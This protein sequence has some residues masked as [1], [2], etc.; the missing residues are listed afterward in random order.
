MSFDDANQVEQF[1]KHDAQ[2]ETSEN[3]GSKLYSLEGLKQ[4]R[5][6]MS[7][8]TAL[9]TL[10]PVDKFLQGGNLLPDL[11]IDGVTPEMAVC[12]SGRPV[13]GDAQKGGKAD[14]QDKS[15]ANP[16][17]KP[18]E[19]KDATTDN[20]ALNANNDKH[21]E[22]VGEMKKA[23][24]DMTPEEETKVR[25][26]LEKIDQ[27]PA[28]QQKKVYE[29][30]EKILTAPTDNTTKLSGEQRYEIAGSMAHQIAHPED[31]KQGEKQT[32]VAANAEK[33]MAMT[34]PDRYA[35]MVSGLA[36]DGKYTVTLPN[37][38]QKTIEA[39]KDA[40]GK[41]ADKTDPN[42]ER[43]YA[44]EVFQNFAMNIPMKDGESYKSYAPGTRESRNEKDKNPDGVKS[45]KDTGERLEK[46][47]PWFWEDKMNKFG[48]LEPGD[49]DTM[50]KTLFPEEKYEDRPIQTADDLRKAY[51]ENKGPLNVGVPINDKEGKF[52]GM[53]NRDGGAGNHAVVITHIEQG[54][55]A[56]V[57]YDNTVSGTPDHTYPKGQGVPIE[58]FA[59]AMKAGQRKATV[60]T[61]Q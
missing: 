14:A 59:A 27:L 41:L 58:E 36:T 12:N 32:C 15:A 29:S 11:H 48:G 43:S 49:K 42:K 51:E 3:E 26:D 55:P 21:N 2:P 60:R 38:D 56:L 47:N 8:N 57:Y 9:P 10:D 24:P 25:Q 45:D 33:T 44:S 5:E 19:A 4:L 52:L 13:S 17:D 20:T 50:F 23:H 16:S 39:Q 35:E 6:I 61:N 18:A 53:G 54:P 30:M 28:D 40:S 46:S 1:Q 31:I 37:G 7:G 22:V 34:H